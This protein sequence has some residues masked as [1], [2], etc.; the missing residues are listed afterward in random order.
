MEREEKGS[1]AAGSA[2]SAAGSGGRKPFSELNIIGKHKALEEVLDTEV[3]PMLAKDGGDVEINDIQIDDD[4]VLV[5]LDYRGACKGCAGAT[6]GT[7]SYIEKTLKERLDP[8]I[9]VATG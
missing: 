5:L 1:A 4:E 9:R 6:T 7:L 3:R 2:D 8:R